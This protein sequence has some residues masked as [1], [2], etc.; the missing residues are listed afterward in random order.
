[1]NQTK[2]TIIGLFDKYM[3]YTFENDTELFSKLVRSEE[4]CEELNEWTKNEMR[5]LLGKGEDLDYEKSIFGYIYNIICEKNIMKC[6]QFYKE[7]F[8]D[9]EELMEIMKLIQ[10]ICKSE[11][12]E[13]NFEL[14]N[15][16]DIYCYIYL[17]DFHSV[18]LKEHI[19][20]LVDPVEPK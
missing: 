2:E 19:I 12:M 1:M 9:S 11:D 18:E 13:I 15:I 3:K 4:E 6:V 10:D 17:F 16:M 20:E 14:P 5:Y 8:N 7:I